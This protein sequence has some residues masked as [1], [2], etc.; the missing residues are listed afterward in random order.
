[1]KM[2]FLQFLSS[3]GVMVRRTIHPPAHPQGKGPQF[4]RPLMPHIADAAASDG[5]SAA[6]GAESAAS[7]ADAA[8]SDA[9][10]QS[11]DD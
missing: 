11:I 5:D 9:A 2:P 8:A 3:Y 7:D 4:L 6:S 1:M 10:T